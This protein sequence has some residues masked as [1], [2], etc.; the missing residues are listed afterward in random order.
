MLNSTRKFVVEIT[1]R[2]PW[3]WFS[4][5]KFR[6]IKLKASQFQNQQGY[7][8]FIPYF[9]N[10]KSTA[11]LNLDEVH[12]NFIFNLEMGTWCVEVD[13]A[14]FYPKSS[15]LSGQGDKWD[16]ISMKVMI[17]ADET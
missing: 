1:D 17:A 2:K 15:I 12:F 4:E 9:D 11:Y 10:V 16:F 6:S 8:I 5:F 7:V 13:F 3:N 14:I